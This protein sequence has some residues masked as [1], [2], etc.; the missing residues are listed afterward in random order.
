MQ[1]CVYKP[2]NAFQ[3]IAVCFIP[4]HGSH[5]LRRLRLVVPH[6][7]LQ[8]P[9]IQRT[10]NLPRALNPDCIRAALGQVP[11]AKQITYSMVESQDDQL[12]I[13]RY[14]YSYRSSDDQVWKDFTLITSN[15]ASAIFHHF[16]ASHP[17]SKGDLHTQREIM[18]KAEAA[19]AQACHLPGG[20]S[21]F[22][23]YCGPR[24]SPLKKNRCDAP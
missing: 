8:P 3:N 23:E 5:P 4:A 12:S 13:H 20:E 22:G 18:Y 14:T 15:N 17:L 11:E 16:S 1:V 6:L 19:V 21:F 9:A 10:G 2:P 24:G 7:Q